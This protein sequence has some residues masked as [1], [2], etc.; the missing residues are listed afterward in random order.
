MNVLEA[1]WLSVAREQDYLAA[2]RLSLHSSQLLSTYMNGLNTQDQALNDLMRPQDSS[3]SP[4]LSFQDKYAKV[5]D[6]A[7]AADKLLWIVGCGEGEGEEARSPDADALVACFEAC[8]AWLEKSQDARDEPLVAGTKALR[9]ALLEVASH[10][11]AAREELSQCQ[12]LLHSLQGLQMEERSLRA[13]EIQF[14][15]RS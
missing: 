10:D 9:N 5:S 15:R 11:E 2:Q 7:E 6:A 14:A 3:S 4:W 12:L 13:G 8:R 1:L